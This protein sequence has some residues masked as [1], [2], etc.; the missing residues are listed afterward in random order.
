MIID[1]WSDDNYTWIKKLERE[2]M[3]NRKL[4]FIRK[5]LIAYLASTIIKKESKENIEMSLNR[6]EIIYDSL[7]NSSLDELILTSKQN[8]IN[9]DKIVER[10]RFFK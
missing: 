2:D 4:I 6:V 10:Y 3:W 5:E 9:I 8:K 7:Y 1:D